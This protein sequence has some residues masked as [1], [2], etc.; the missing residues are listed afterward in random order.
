M[1]TVTDDRTEGPRHPWPP[2]LFLHETKGTVLALV[3]GT[4]VATVYGGEPLPSQHN[5]YQESLFASGGP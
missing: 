2:K 4:V 1:T 5:K 3:S